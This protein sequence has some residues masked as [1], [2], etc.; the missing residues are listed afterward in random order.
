MSIKNRNKP[1]GQ[2]KARAAGP[3]IQPQD[4]AAGVEEFM[5]GRS[6]V[7]MLA[8]ALFLIG[9]GYIFL[10]KTDPA[11]E[12]SY[13][14]LAPVFLLAGY[15]LVPAALLVKPGKKPAEP[16]DLPGSGLQPKL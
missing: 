1:L 8:L 9:S 16:R 4:H 7:R 6:T 3:K 5:P 14:I 15:L 13:A 11:G 2:S 10:K 12:N